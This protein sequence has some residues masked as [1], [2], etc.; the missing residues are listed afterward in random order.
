MKD[1]YVFRGTNTHAFR[2]CK[3]MSFYY[4]IFSPQEDTYLTST[5]FD[6]LDAMING[7]GRCNDW[8]HLSEGAKP[9]LVAIKFGNYKY[10][11]GEEGPIE[12]EI[13]GKI[14]FNDVVVINSLDKLKEIY[15]PNKAETEFFLKY[16]N[17]ENET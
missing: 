2:I 13:L 5:S 4:G 14:D 9:V 11:E 15:L 7:V 6:L 12:T 10:R 3:E 17:L 8:F 16:H 1:K